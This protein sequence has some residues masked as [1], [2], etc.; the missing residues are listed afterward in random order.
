MADGEDLT[1]GGTPGDR[2]QR[3]DGAGGDVL[4]RLEAGRPAVG[5]EVAGPVVLDLPGGEA[6]PLAGVVLAQLRIE[7]DR[8]DA[9]LVGDDLGGAP[10]PLEV[11]RHDEVEDAEPARRLGCLALTQLRQRRVGLALPAAGRVPRRLPMADQ[12]DASG[13]DE[14]G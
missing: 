3:G 13:H 12:Q 1:I 8:P 4:R 14:R 7:L 5:G 2:Q 11:A 10:R 6:L 9:E